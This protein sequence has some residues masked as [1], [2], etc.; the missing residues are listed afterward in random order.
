M[1]LKLFIQLQLLAGNPFDKIT[2]FLKD[3]LIKG[4]LKIATPISALGF[5]SLGIGAMMSTD[6]HAR[7]KFKSGMIWL[8]AATIVCFLGSTIVDWLAQNFK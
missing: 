6:E 2:D 3:D 4:F 1:L 5:I 8:G 7:Q